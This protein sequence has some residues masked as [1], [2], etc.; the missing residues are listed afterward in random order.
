MAF[1]EDFVIISNKVGI[2]CLKK[3]DISYQK[4]KVADL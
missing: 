4:K 2:L 1:K 3:K